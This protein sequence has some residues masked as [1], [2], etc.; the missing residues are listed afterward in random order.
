MRRKQNG[1]QPRDAAEARTPIL[2]LA[3]WVDLGGSDKGTIDWFRSIDRTRWAPSLITT[4]PSANRWLPKVEPYAEEVWD[5]PD[6]MPGAAFPSFILGFIESRGVEVVHIMNSRL[7]FD[8][9]PDMTCLT[10]PPAVVV[11]LHAEEPDKS[12]YVRYVTRRYGN[13]VDAFSVT[14]RQ[15]LDIVAG[16]DI[17]P[18]KIEV[19]HSGVDGHDEFDPERVAP[20]EL[21]GNGAPRILWPGRLVEQK[22]PLLTLDVLARVRERG[23]DFVLD[24]VGDGELAPVVK[25]HAEKLGVADAIC[26][27]PPCQDMAPWYRSA[28]LLLMTSVFEGVPYVV[29]ESLAM[30]VPVVAPA[31]PG[32]RE[33]MDSDSGTLVEPRD[34]VEQYATAISALLGNRERRLE[35][36]ARSRQRML[37]EFSLS[38][39][40]GRHDALYERLLADRATKS[41]AA[42]PFGDGALAPSA[43]DAPAPPPAAASL[44][45]RDP[46]P[47]RTVGVIVPC[48][49]HGIYLDDCIESI[50]AQTLAPAAIVVVDDGSKDP[51]TIAALA[52]YDDDPDVTILRQ[53]GN[54]GPSA[55]RNR[56]LAELGDD[57]SY[58]LPLDADDELL[59]D[60]LERM[61]AQLEAAPVDVGFVYP[62]AQH[63]GNRRDFVP[64]P[65]YNLW[66]LMVDNYCPAPA[67]FDRRA[68]E[69]GATYPEDMVFGHEDWDFLLQL[70]ELGVRGEHVSEPTFLYRKYGFSRIN[71]VEYGPHAFHDAV[72]RRHPALYRNS[73]TLKAR[74]SPALSVVLLDDEDG[75]RAWRQEDL[76]RLPKQSCADFEVV[77]SRPLAGDVHVAEPE[78]DSPAGR[79]QA[80]IAAARG[81]WVCV[82]TPRALPALLDPSLVERLVYCFWSHEWTCAVVLGEAPGV[83]RAAFAQLTDDERMDALPVAIAFERIPEQPSPPVELGLTGS[84]IADM[85]VSIQARG[86][87]Q[88]RLAPAADRPSNG[89]G[90]AALNGSVELNGPGPRATAPAGPGAGAGATSYTGAVAKLTLDRA[91]ARDDAEAW[92]QRAVSWQ[93]P[94]LPGLTAGAVR[95]WETAA[96]WIPPETDTLTRHR[97][98][99]GDDRVVTIGRQSPPGYGIE[100]DLGVLHR[101][102]FP[103][104]R[105]LVQDGD[106][107]ALTEDENLLT[108]GRRAL[109]YV[110]QAPLPLLEVLELRRLP[111]SGRHV[112]VAGA[113]DPL[114]NS[115]EHLATLGWIES[116]PIQPRHT[117]L[118]LGP[119]GAVALRRYVDRDAWRHR[120]RTGPPGDEPD[121]VSLGALMRGP[122]DGLLPLR[123]RPDGRL[124]T[125][126]AGPSRARRTPSAVARW[127]AAPLAWS[128]GPPP[129]W[130]QRAT[131]SR[132]RHLL[133]PPSRRAVAPPGGPETLGWLRIEPATGHSPLF[134][135]THPVTGDQL[136]TRST[137]EATDLGYRVDGLLGHVVD[138]GAD[139]MSTIAATSVLWGS[140]FGKGRRYVEGPYDG[141]GAAR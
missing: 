127:I 3:P 72:E 109:G 102:A 68:L 45:D 133:A 62:S 69:A 107:F 88:W 79:L 49:R 83:E 58:V 2:Y 119:W 24:V 7:G 42:V 80:C 50:K 46:P 106:T 8:L 61:V 9:L 132:V 117:P 92:V 124:E 59:P 139:G 138:A 23:A 33:F 52:R 122:G 31:L 41:S 1:S 32:N 120:Y 97:A 121:A 76:A 30:E 65:A 63:S 74:W 140:R 17:A 48:H 71:A 56:A 113:D 85:V 36:G 18:S 43:V 26:W 35:M 67:L 64:S 101:F 34:D 78:D 16:Y 4:Q 137:L 11:Q 25:A 131:A 81:R 130:A 95:R 73:D 135:A 118:H 22:D 5:L 136:L 6:L 91:P 13:L 54:Y 29:Y 84:L 114:Y 28:D 116:F 51:E 53:D 20:L 96:A 57:L 141:S 86:P 94:R 87:V 98:L 44:F 19:I 123:V 125:D 93:E 10:D 47:E 104:T 90:R 110:E 111:D 128:G 21:P 14:S 100:F 39:M 126:L 66:I 89:N 108:D 75:G 27:H 103:G 60:A 70:A 82:L 55:A 129:A 12:G 115:A 77:A 99:D 38:A 37:A 40:G 112:L 134:S 15:L 105:R